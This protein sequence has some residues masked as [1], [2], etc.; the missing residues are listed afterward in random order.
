MASQCLTQ[1]P[2]GV[3]QQFTIPELQA[4]FKKRPNFDELSFVE[5]SSEFVP[6]NE[7][8]AVTNYVESCL[9]SSPKSIVE[10][11]ITGISGSGKS[12]SLKSV[13]K[14]FRNYNIIPLFC[15][16]F[17]KISSEIGGQTIHSLCPIGYYKNANFSKLAKKL[18][19]TPELTK[20]FEKYSAIII[21]CCSASLFNYFNLVLQIAKENKDPFGGLHI[22]LCGDTSQLDCVCATSL[23]SHSQNVP[24]FAKEGLNLFRKFNTVFVL[25]NNQRQVED[26]VFQRLLMRM[27]RNEVTQADV[28]LLNSRRESV[29]SKKELKKFEDELLLFPQND[30]TRFKNQSSLTELGKPIRILQNPSSWITTVRTFVLGVKSS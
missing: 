13:G 12:E 23:S 17:G 25:T 22:V 29:L 14:V 8:R 24:I 6:N 7:Q 30:F 27:R 26:K 1:C 5:V 20:R 4:F 9:S 15:S 16:A 11:L 28:D 21:T 19:K 3:L 18:K 2:E 10:I